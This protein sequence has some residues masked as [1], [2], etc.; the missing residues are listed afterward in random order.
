[1]GA[2]CCWQNDEPVTEV[3]PE[4]KP[5]L[6]VPQPSLT[7]WKQSDQGAG[8]AGEEFTVTFVKRGKLGLNVKKS[9]FLIREI[10]PVGAVADYNASAPSLL[11]IRR[12][13][14]VV[15]VNGRRLKPQEM[16][17]ETNEHKD[18]AEISFTILRQLEL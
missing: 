1:M 17:N 3:F 15:A 7:G 6:S 8:D 4:A 13:D 9:E 5:V 12:G 2:S 14:K 11:Q 10:K 16:L 18:G